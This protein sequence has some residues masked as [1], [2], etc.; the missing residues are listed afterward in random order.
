[1]KTKSYTYILPMMEYFTDV[2]KRNLVNTF[3][4]A[5]DFP[6]LTN[7][8]FLL[9]K[10]HGT[11]DFVLYEEELEQCT[12]F[13]SKYDPDSSHVMFVFN[14][15]EDYQEVYDLYLKGKYSEFPKDYKVQIFKFHDIVDSSHR[16]AKVL[17]KHPDLKEELEDRIGV[18]I[19]KGQEVSSI[20]DLD[21]EIYENNM[22]VIN[23]VKPQKNPFE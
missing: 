14:V 21:V 20:P 15:P 6:E 2:R 19:P 13:H 18:D 4:G 23:P 3:V 22:K 12:L 10:F 16:V 7:H 8:I 1:M 9:Y 17:F 11:K 5:R